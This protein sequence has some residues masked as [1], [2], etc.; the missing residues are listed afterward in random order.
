MPTSSLP[1][2]PTTTKKR[3][4]PP[5]SST[6]QEKPARATPALRPNGGIDDGAAGRKRGASRPSSMNG[7]TGGVPDEDI[8]RNGRNMNG[9][10]HRRL[11]E[12]PSS[13]IGSARDITGRRKRVRP[14]ITTKVNTSP[15]GGEDVADRLKGRQVAA[16]SRRAAQGKR[17]VRA[18]TEGD[19]DDD[20]I[21]RRS[22]PGGSHEQE[23]EEEDDLSYGG[24]AD[25]DDHEA[26]DPDEEDDGDVDEDGGGMRGKGRG[27]RKKSPSAA[28]TR[29]SDRSKKSAVKLEDECEFSTVQVYF[30]RCLAFSMV[31]SMFP[32]E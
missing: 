14:A 8:V 30:Y 5:V 17:D 20:E 18:E 10:A 19:D 27:N 13:S 16:T 2:P 22:E 31:A 3:G 6:P 1:P 12:A 15:S 25:E 26:Y 21:D 9:T 11:N 32:L 29:R 7:N 4:R 23:G 28:A 24:S